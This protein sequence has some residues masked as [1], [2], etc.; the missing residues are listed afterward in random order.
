MGRDGNIL[1]AV[2][3]QAW[4]DGMLRALAKN[5]PAKATGAHIA[6]VGHITRDELRR[7]LT[8]TDAANGFANRFLFVASR[9]SKALPEGGHLA[10]EALDGLV[11]RLAE[12]LVLAMGAGE[13][14]RD[15]IGR[16][17]V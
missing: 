1:S 8:Q 17:H 7:E 11:Q 6:L 2:I 16:A 15:E 4:D 12:A 9:R 3:R 5:S 13:L 10:P 14:S